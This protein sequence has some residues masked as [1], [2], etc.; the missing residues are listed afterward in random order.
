MTPHN[1]MPHNMISHVDDTAQYHVVSITFGYIQG[2]QCHMTTFQSMCI[3][4]DE[5]RH[6]RDLWRADAVERHSGFNGMPG[7]V[8]GTAEARKD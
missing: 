1:M 5:H 7:S 3:L 8:K 4:A 2:E 6:G